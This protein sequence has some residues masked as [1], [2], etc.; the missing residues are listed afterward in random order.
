TS[1]DRPNVGL[2][3]KIAFDA[4]D[5]EVLVRN[6]REVASA[7]IEHADIGAAYLAGQ[8]HTEI[9]WDFFTVQETDLAA[10]EWVG[11]GASYGNTGQR[12]RGGACETEHTRVF[13]E[14]RALFR[15][16]DR[17]TGQINLPRIHFSFAEVGVYSA[18]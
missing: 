10:E 11:I 18:G 17:K 2:A 15:K 16:E 14:K 13:K 4:A 6:S 7:H 12:S 1:E 9:D 3:E 5:D 8:F